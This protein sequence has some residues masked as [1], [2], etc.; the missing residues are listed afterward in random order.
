MKRAPANVVSNQVMQGV[1]AVW[2][3]MRSWQRA[4]PVWGIIEIDGP[5]MG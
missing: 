1:P 2:E 4:L 5:Q 3:G